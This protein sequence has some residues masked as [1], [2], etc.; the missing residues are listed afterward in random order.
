MS[1]FQP[2]VLERTRTLFSDSV[3]KDPKPIRYCVVDDVES[4]R[5]A[6]K[7][8][9]S[10]DKGWV[11]VGEYASADVAFKEIQL[12]KPR[13]VLMDILM[14][15]MSGLEC[16]RRLKKLLPNL[17]ILVVTGIPN[18]DLFWQCIRAGASGYLVKPI[19]PTALITAIRDTLEGHISVTPD[20]FTRLVE[21]AP[22]ILSNFPSL[23]HREEEIMEHVANGE[24]SKQIAGL[25][26]ITEET[27]NRH[28][29]N[30]HK[31]W[32]IQSR[33]QAVNKYR[34]WRINRDLMQ[35]LCA[36]RE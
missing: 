3:P 2:Q 9:L 33:V 15:G 18:E 13:I 25:L 1:V 21:N 7:L 31:K 8:V 22:E 11:C 10:E 27:V 4:V 26:K 34:A 12:V 17:T 24:G 6:A 20:I 28:E 5:Q 29:A 32:K 16:T 35:F 30:I 14:P 19:T 23:T 36:D